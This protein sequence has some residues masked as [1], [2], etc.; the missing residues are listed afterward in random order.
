MITVRRPLRSFRPPARLPGSLWG[1][2]LSRSH[3]KDRKT[4]G[5]GP[6]AS[7]RQARL[8]F[9]RE[10]EPADKE[11]TSG[12]HRRPSSVGCGARAPPLAILW[13]AWRSA[14][15]RP[16]GAIGTARGGRDSADEWDTVH[17]CAG[18]L[19]CARAEHLAGSLR[20]LRALPLAHRPAAASTDHQRGASSRR[21]DDE[22]MGGHS[23]ALAQSARGAACHPGRRRLS[24]LGRRCCEVVLG[25]RQCGTTSDSD[26]LGDAGD[27]HSTS[28]GQ[29]AHPSLPAHRWYR[30]ALVGVDLF[31]PGDRPAGRSS[32]AESDRARHATI[33]RE[34][35]GPECHVEAA[36]TRERP[37]CLHALLSVGDCCGGGLFVRGHAGSADVSVHRVATGTSGADRHGFAS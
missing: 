7:R 24:C 10:G 18:R 17:G 33:H 3:P 27:T 21:T 16:P 36:R 8:D 37:E 4:R 6:P 34:C 2:F 13:S 5:E 15:V 31:P 28:S 23:P 22:P 32:S 35:G 20:R 14:L 1:P 29:Y 19:Q 11:G 26:A 25:W 9:D 30:S 12:V